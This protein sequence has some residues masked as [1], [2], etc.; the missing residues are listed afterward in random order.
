MYENQFHFGIS[1][2]TLQ[3]F[4]FDLIAKNNSNRMK[5]FIRKF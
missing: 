4:S 2:S 3:L 1:R 5:M